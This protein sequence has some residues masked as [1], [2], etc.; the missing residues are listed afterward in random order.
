VH[1]KLQPEV[2]IIHGMEQHVLLVD[3]YSGYAV[4]K[5]VLVVGEVNHLLGLIPH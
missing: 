2:R 1:G 5:P 4:M 3:C